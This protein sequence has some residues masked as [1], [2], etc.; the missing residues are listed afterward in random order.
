MV[1]FNIQDGM[2]MMLSLSQE[3]IPAQVLLTGQV[4]H[5]VQ[6]QVV[7]CKCHMVSWPLMRQFLLAL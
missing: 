1:Q 2:S 6:V 3:E 7:T 4:I 5:L